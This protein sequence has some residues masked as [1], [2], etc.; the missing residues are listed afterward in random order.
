MKT[1]ILFLCLTSPIFAQTWEEASRPQR[2]Y[3]WLSEEKPQDTTTIAKNKAYW[4][5]RDSLCKSRGHAFYD[6]GTTL[7]TNMPYLVDK[8]NASLL[9][10]RTTTKHAKCYRCDWTLR[11]VKSDTTIIWRKQ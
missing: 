2:S 6:I 11:F 1:L 9:I 3:E 7:Y 5:R 10:K 4:A 8:E